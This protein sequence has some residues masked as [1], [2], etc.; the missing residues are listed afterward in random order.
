MVFPCAMIAFDRVRLTYR[1]ETGVKR[2]MNSNSLIW[3]LIGVGVVLGGL[4]LLLGTPPEEATAPVQAVPVQTAPAQS[5]SAPVVQPSQPVAV[6]EE[7][8]FWEP[9]SCPESA[10]TCP[11]APEEPCGSPCMEKT[12]PSDGCSEVPQPC[13]CEDGCEQPFLGSLLPPSEPPHPRDRPKPEIDRHYP[14]AIDEGSAI[15]LLAWIANPACASVCFTWSV[16][17]GWLEDPDTL[18]PIYHAPESD[19]AG[20]ETVTITFAIRDEFGGRSYDQIRIRINNLDYDGPS[21]P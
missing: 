10:G 16:S 21:V 7:T 18:T 11:A 2:A 17:K 8:T 13:S 9:V 1:A 12:P 15:P 14:P 19:R 3:I 4:L 6:S 5:Q 20:G